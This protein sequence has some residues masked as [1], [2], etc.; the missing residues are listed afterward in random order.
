M[1]LL[2]H[3]VFPDS[4]PKCTRNAGKVLRLS[5]FRKHLNWLKKR[6]KMLSLEDYVAAMGQPGSRKQS[7]IAITFDDGYRSTFDLVRP[8]LLETKVPAT[9]FVTT[10]HLQNNELLWFVYFNA[11]CFEKAYQNITID[12]IR[13]PLITEKACYRAWR[14]LIDMARASGDAPAFSQTYAKRYPIP[15]NIIQ[16]YFGLTP[17]QISSFRNHSSIELGGHTH[18]HPYLDQISLTEQMDEIITNKHILETLSG[19]PVRYF[20]YTGGVYNQD[21]LKAVKH[22]GFTAA[23]AV[24]PLQLSDEARFELPRTDVYSPSLMR[25]KIKS[26]LGVQNTLAFREK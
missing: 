22:A 4:T 13:Y 24:K 16:R 10:A 7:N 3:L 21:T 5:D 25:L 19:Q 11:L 15:Q 12:G 9:F 17:D 23:C 2:Y 14:R 8:V 26:I 20:A 18:S 6:F 1:I